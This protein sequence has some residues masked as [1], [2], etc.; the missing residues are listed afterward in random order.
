[1]ST[2]MHV[3]KSVRILNVRKNGLNIIR[4]KNNRV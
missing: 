2:Y 1:M 4:S 3:I